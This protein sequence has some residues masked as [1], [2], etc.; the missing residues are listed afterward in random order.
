MMMPSVHSSKESPAE[1]PAPSPSAIRVE[2]MLQKSTSEDLQS[3]G[4]E[5][6]APQSQAVGNS[7]DTNAKFPQ[8][9]VMADSAQTGDALP[10]I[11]VFSKS[12]TDDG[13]HPPLMDWIYA[14]TNPQPATVSYSALVLSEVRS[15]GYQ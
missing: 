11:P 6:N 5:F 2:I 9:E 12:S 8:V 15:R 1:N 7:Q 14:T 10:E 13:V 4:T 3:M